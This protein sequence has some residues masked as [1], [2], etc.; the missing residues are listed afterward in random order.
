MTRVDYEHR[1]E[2]AVEKHGSREAAE[3]ELRRF[4]RRLRRDR[5]LRLSREDR[6]L[7]EQAYRYSK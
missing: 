5:A 1:I 4:V 7:L 3:A 6:L 2:V